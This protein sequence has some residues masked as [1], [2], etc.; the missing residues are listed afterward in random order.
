[1]CCCFFVSLVVSSV[2]I[3][4]WQD[5]LTVLGELDSWSRLLWY[6]VLTPSY[7]GIINK[8]SFEIKGDEP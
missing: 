1:M 7:I 2:G 5:C 6:I 3:L 4:S 8:E